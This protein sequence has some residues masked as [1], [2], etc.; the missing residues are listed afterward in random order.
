MNQVEALEEQLKDEKLRVERR[1]AILRLAKNPDFRKVIIE[2]FCRNQCARYVHESGDPSLPAEQRADALAIA[3][4]A[5]HLKRFLNV[6]IT[7]GDVASRT[8]IDL[9]QAIEEARANDGLEEIE[10]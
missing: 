3:L 1:D 9:N 4:S 2:E 8:V 7:M 5:G 6:N 10:E